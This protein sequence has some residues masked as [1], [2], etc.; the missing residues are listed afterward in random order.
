M[1]KF[2]VKEEFKKRYKYIYEN[3]KLILLPYIYADLNKRVGF[4]EPDELFLTNLES[5]LL[6]DIKMEKSDL[7]KIVESKK[8]DIKELSR[9][10]SVMDLIGNQEINTI[11]GRRYDFGSILLDDWDILLLTWAFIKSQDLR[12]KVVNKELDALNSYF[13]MAR[14]TNDGK[15]WKGGRYRSPYD[16]YNGIHPKEKTHRI[17]EESIS[18]NDKRKSNIKPGIFINTIAEFKNNNE[19]FLEE[20][21][22]EEIYFSLHDEI[23]W[24]LEIECDINKSELNSS[25]YNIPKCIKKIRVDEDKIFINPNSNIN[26]YLILCPHCGRIVN[27]NDSLLSDGVKLRIEKRCQKDPYL[28]RKMC[29]YSELQL[30]KEINSESGKILLKKESNI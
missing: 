28:F 8:S 10:K 12:N 16:N 2:E 17:I 6:S 20:S 3:S 4:R 22:K 18:K 27:V 29:L 9:I 5:F 13:E 14:Y 24:N 15:V 25:E 7:Y 19:T 30:I 1:D 26:R 21:D 23:P 11:D